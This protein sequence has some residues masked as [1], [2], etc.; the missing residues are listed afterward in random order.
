[1]PLFQNILFPIDLNDHTEAYVKKTVKLLEPCESVIH[2]LHVIK[3]SA[4][5]NIMQRI[6]NYAEETEIKKHYADIEIKLN[7]WKAFIEGSLSSI[8]V[9]IH[10]MI[11]GHVQDNIIL[12]ALSI[13]PTLIILGGHAIHERFHLYKSIST[14]KISDATHCT[15][16]KVKPLATGNKV[17]SIIIPVRD[18]IS[19][20]IIEFVIELGKRCR[21]RIYLLL[22]VENLEDKNERHYNSFLRAYRMLH[23]NLNTPIEYRLVVDHHFTKLDKE[24][25]RNIKTDML[26]VDI[27]KREKKFFD[28]RYIENFLA[29]GA[30]LELLTN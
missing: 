19:D 4:H 1:M 29:R 14:C 28:N 22:I 5:W 9:K 13:K 15:I 16:L 11:G 7:K 27:G 8:T 18:L 30:Q 10:L 25:T 21:A 23:A 6:G 17:K 3:P 26:L 12:T 2:L 24:Y 20:P